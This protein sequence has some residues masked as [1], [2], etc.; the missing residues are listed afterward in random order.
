LVRVKIPESREGLVRA[1]LTRREE[2]DGF[3]E[4][5][6]GSEQSLELPERAPSR[7]RRNL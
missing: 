2:L 3:V 4:G 5:L 1:A 7:P 6:F